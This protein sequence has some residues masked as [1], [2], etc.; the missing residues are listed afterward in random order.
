MSLADIPFGHERRADVSS[1]LLSRWG[2]RALIGAP[3]RRPILP[4][5][6]GITHEGRCILYAAATVLDEFI[7]IGPKARLPKS[8]PFWIW[9]NGELM[10][11]LELIDEGELV[12]GHPVVRVKVIRGNAGVNP[13][14]G[15]TTRE[16]PKGSA[17]TASQLRGIF[18]HAKTMMV[19]DL[20]VSIGSANIN[21][22]VVSTAR[23]CFA[24]PNSLKQPLITR[25]EYCVRTLGRTAGYSSVHGSGFASGSHCGL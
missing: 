7:K 24:V 25:P 18:V 17:A 6:G 10:L 4:S 20:L 19:D 13:R 9:I 3:M 2:S 16:H 23:L 14:W 15:A 1:R 12:D 8:S 21:R 5:P 11:A 22:R